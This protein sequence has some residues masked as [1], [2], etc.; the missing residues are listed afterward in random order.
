MVRFELKKIISKPVSRIALLVQAAVLCIVCSIA[1]GNVRYVDEN[2]DTIRGIAAARA[3]REAK[4]QWSGYMTEELLAGVVEENA[5]ISRSDE[6]LSKDARE[7]E[8]AYSKKQGFSDIRDLINRAFCGFRE[9]DYYRID[10]LTAAEMGSFYERR[11]DGLTEWLYS[12][13]AVHHFSEAEKRYLIGRYQKLETPLYYEYFGGWEAALQDAPMIIMLTL[14]IA[15]FLVYGIFSDEMQLKAD[16]VFFSA[17]LGR[18]KAVA[19]KIRAGFWLI[20]AVYWITLLC[21]SAVVLTALGFEGA[22]CAIQLGS[23]NWKSFYSLSYLQDYLLTVL[24]GYLGSL[25]ILTLSMLVSA[26][27]HSGILAVTVPFILLFIPEFLRGI[28]ALSGI[29][30]LL[31]DQLL[32]MCTAVQLFNTYQLG[33]WVVGAA[34][35]ILAAYFLLTGM[36]FPALYRIYRKTEVK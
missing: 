20:T 4:M 21:Y 1:I 6:Y 24:G 23:S 16:S 13:E 33:S 18:S 28:S 22:G 29:L 32:Q 3:L 2:G 36:L 12:D 9:Y 15:G 14:L 26:G 30:G 10:S 19:A 5:R 8:K 35:V 25:F 27:T 34:P 17:K 31:P 11:I 7:N